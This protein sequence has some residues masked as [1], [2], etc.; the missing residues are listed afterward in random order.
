MTARG[1]D[2]VAAPALAILGSML[3]TNLGAA[4]AKSL[5]PQV[6]S[7]GMTALRVGMAALI[8]MLAWRP[9]RMAPGR[10]ALPDLAVYGVMLGCMNLLIYRAFSLIPIGLHGGFRRRHGHV[11]ASRRRRSRHHGGSMRQ[12][13]S[14][15]APPWSQARPPA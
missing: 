6:G 12:Q 5:F 8:L 11:R 3:S 4:F 7:A 15:G 10:A 14:T 2:G 9:W 1:A 13:R